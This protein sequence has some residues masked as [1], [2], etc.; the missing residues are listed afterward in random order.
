MIEWSE[1]KADTKE[2]RIF[3][4]L[5][6]EITPSSPKEVKVFFEKSKVK[7]SLHIAGGMVDVGFAA[8][9]FY[10]NVL[11][12]YDLASQQEY[13]KL[14]P[15]NDKVTLYK[16]GKM[17]S[18]L[19]ALAADSVA[20]TQYGAKSANATASIFNRGLGAQAMQQHLPNLSTKLARKLGLNSIIA[21]S[22]H[23]DTQLS[24]VPIRGLVAA[25]NIGVAAIYFTDAYTANRSGNDG[26]RDGHLIG[27]AS[28]LLM[29]GTLASGPIGW[30]CFAV[31]MAGLF[32]SG[33]TITR[34]Q[35]TDFENLLFSCFWGKSEYYSFWADFIDAEK[36]IKIK[37]RLDRLEKML[38]DQQTQKYVKAAFEIE[39]QEFINYFYWPQLEVDKTAMSPDVIKSDKLF[40]FRFVLPEFKMGISQLHGTLVKK[41][42][43]RSGLASTEPMTEAFKH[44]LVA[45]LNNPQQHEF[46]QD[47]LHLTV[48]VECSF[49]QSRGIA[50]DLSLKWCYEPEP[51]LVVPKRML[52]SS[53]SIDGHMIGMLDE[54]PNDKY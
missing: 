26:L 21:Y 47:G 38:S 30:A 29:L 50:S 24:K 15:I 53:G 32:W 41:L 9:S 16:L 28:S 14:D 3:Q 52:T 42:Y 27:G 31:A 33:Y 10:Y 46:K 39:S 4:L 49:G 2:Q 23:M 12:M 22:Q 51:A 25:A 44:A 37:Y 54:R 35:K 1:V 34:F 5:E 18:T 43:D 20:L 48:Q 17:G 11:A 13:A 45:A 19:M 6:L 40:T 36:I 8:L 7:T